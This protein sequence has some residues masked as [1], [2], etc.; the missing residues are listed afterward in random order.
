[1]SVRSGAV[2]RAVCVDVDAGWSGLSSL[3]SGLARASENGNRIDDFG[4]CEACCG[5]CIR[6]MMGETLV[7]MGRFAVSEKTERPSRQRSV[8]GR[9]GSSQLVAPPERGQARETDDRH[10]QG[11]LCAMRTAYITRRLYPKHIVPF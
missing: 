5:P 10:S 8:R 9:Q 6:R 1:M 2:G 4:R 11:R 7:L 3:D